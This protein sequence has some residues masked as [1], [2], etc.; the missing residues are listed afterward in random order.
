MLPSLLVLAVIL[1]AVAAY[2]D[3][4][5]QIHIAL[6]GRAS[7]GDA[8]GMAV[9]WNTKHRTTSSTVRYGRR[10]GV[11]TERATGSASAYYE[12]YNHHVVLPSLLPGTRYYYTVGDELGGW[13]EEQSF[14]SAPAASELRGNFS[15]FVFGDLGVVNGEHSLEY[16][17]THTD[18]NKD[19]DNAA[20]IWHAGDVSYAD[21]SFLHKDCVL[22]FCYEDVLD[23]YLR[24]T[25]SFA[26]AVPYMVTP[27]NHEAGECVCCY[28]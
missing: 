11:Y 21:D 13:S 7:S 23:D 24:R 22:R 14:T 25:E 12:T 17:R 18:R 9:S 27:G 10:P 20:L 4:P 3:V 2:S 19:P 28:L 16:L 6:A 8:D 1:A 5:T 15:F 26:S